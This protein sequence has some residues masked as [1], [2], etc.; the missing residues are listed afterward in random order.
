MS[1][2]NA[3]DPF[4][5]LGVSRDADE[6][7]IRARYLELVKQYPPE[8]DAEKFHQ[9]RAAFDAVKDPLAVAMRLL[10]PPDLDDTGVSLLTR[11]RAATI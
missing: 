10:I 3:D 5:I 11:K 2:S 7:E 1:L 4:A 8:R 6:S 9:I